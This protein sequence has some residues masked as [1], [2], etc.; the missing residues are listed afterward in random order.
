VQALQDAMTRSIPTVFRGTV[1]VLVL[2]RTP[3]LTCL[4][5]GC[6]R[7]MPAIAKWA[8][9]SYIPIYGQMPAIAKWATAYPSI[10]P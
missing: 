5:P 10:S 9:A 3:P 7:Q 1:T 8:K 4:P 6:V 2:L